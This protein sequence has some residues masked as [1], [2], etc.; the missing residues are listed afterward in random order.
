M[1]FFSLIVNLNNLMRFL[2]ISS[3]FVFL[4]LGVL[5]KAGYQPILTLDE[6]DVFLVPY[7]NGKIWKIKAGSEI[8]EYDL[9]NNELTTTTVCSGTWPAVEK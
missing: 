1:R 4:L 8:Q 6:T 9:S 7:T 3:I 2:L 5:V